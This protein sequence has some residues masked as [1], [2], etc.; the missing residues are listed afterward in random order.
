L[1][2]PRKLPPR[3]APHAESDY[4][5]YCSNVTP[6]GGRILACLS[7]ESANLTAACKAALSA[8]EAK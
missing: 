1:L 5:K 6:G 3:S 7:K 8:A 4:E 2:Q